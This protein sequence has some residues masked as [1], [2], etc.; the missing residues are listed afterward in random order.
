MKNRLIWYIKQL[1]PLRYESTYSKDGINKEHCV[2]QMWFG[3]CFNMET[4]SIKGDE[5]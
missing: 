2:W 5:L 4:F 3:K 1:L